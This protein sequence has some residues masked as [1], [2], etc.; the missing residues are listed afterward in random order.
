[1]SRLFQYIGGYKKLFIAPTLCFMLLDGA[2]IFNE[3]SECRHMYIIYSTFISFLIQHIKDIR[4][5]VVSWKATQDLL[6]YQSEP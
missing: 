3:T 1:M 2:A 6:H 5:R 4:C